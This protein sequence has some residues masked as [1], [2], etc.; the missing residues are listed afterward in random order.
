M[1]LKASKK[2]IFSLKFLLAQT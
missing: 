1:F 2:I